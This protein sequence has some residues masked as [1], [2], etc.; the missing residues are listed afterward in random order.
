MGGKQRTYLQSYN[1]RL[2]EYGQAVA[3]RYKCVSQHASQ[4]THTKASAAGPHLGLRIPPMS[5]SSFVRIAQTASL[6]SCRR[7]S[8]RCTCSKEWSRRGGQV[9]GQPSHSYSRWSSHARTVLSSSPVHNQNKERQQA[10]S[11][12]V[13]T[14][15]T[16]GSLLCTSGDMYMQLPVSPAEVRQSLIT[17]FPAGGGQGAGSFPITVWTERDR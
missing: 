16:H 14:P 13:V 7:Q 5:P 3:R 9:A 6:Q 1:A 17:P 15:T 10:C 12:L 8:S 2:R 11:P 4:N